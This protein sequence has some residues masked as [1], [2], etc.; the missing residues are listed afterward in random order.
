MAFDGARFAAHEDVVDPL[1]GATMLRVPLTS[2]RELTPFLE[3]LAA[4][5][6]AGLHNRACSI[7]WPTH[8]TIHL[9][10]GRA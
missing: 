2:E 9:P 3:S 6:K 1:T 4:V 7:C 5:P 8:S 10:S